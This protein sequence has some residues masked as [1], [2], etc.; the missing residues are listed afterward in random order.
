MATYKG[1]DPHDDNKWEEK[2]RFAKKNYTNGCKKNRIIL[3][4]CIYIINVDI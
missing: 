2:E 3:F 4:F 1:L